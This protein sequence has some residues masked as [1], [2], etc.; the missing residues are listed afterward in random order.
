VTRDDIPLALDA[1]FFYSISDAAKA[2][3]R[4]RSITHLLPKFVYGVVRDAAGAFAMR[5]LFSRMEELNSEA[6]K[7]L[8]FAEEEW[9]VRIVGL[10]ILKLNLPED[11]LNALIRPV[12]AEQRAIAA[13]F[14]AEARRVAIEV[15]GD[16]ARR[17]HRDALTY[18]Y[19]KALE[20]IASAPGA[21]V[22]LPMAFPKLIDGLRAGVGVG[23]GIGL[24]ADKEAKVIDEIAKRIG[25]K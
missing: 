12:T 5:D 25:G 20:K 24:T 6:E 18:L 10:E 23:L 4:V 3:L 9:G 11:V 21:R 13:R 14:E 16:A 1:V 17:L 8:R 19:L 15:L 2:I 22:V 7:R